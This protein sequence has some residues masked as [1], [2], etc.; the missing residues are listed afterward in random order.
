MF[1]MSL[2]GKKIDNVVSV[3]QYNSSTFRIL[4]RDSAGKLDRIEIG[5]AHV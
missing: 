2:N 5:R 1:N 3:T 4:Y